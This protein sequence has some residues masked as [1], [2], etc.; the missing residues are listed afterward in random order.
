MILVKTH[1]NFRVELQEAENS[2]GVYQTFVHK[3]QGKEKHGGVT[4]RPMKN[5]LRRL[6]N[7][8]HD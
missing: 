7:K 8:Y 6:S 2:A 4:V 3:L 1:G 5:M